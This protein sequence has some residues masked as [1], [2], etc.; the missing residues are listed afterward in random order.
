MESSSPE[1][2]LINDYKLALKF[3]VNK[4]FAKSFSI[5]EKLHDFC[6]KHFELGTLGEEYF[7][8][9]VTL[10]LTEVSLLVNP[11]DGNGYQ[12]SKV[13][14]KK[15][16]QKLEQGEFLDKLYGTYG[17]IPKIPLELLFQVFLVNYTCQNVVSTEH[18]A[19]ARQFKK[20]YSLLDFSTASG[21]KY[22]KRWVDMYVFNVLPD[23]DDFSTAF[24]VAEENPLINTDKARNKLEELQELKK[25][26]KKVRE[27]KAQEL[28]SKEARRLEEEKAKQR[29][30]KDE[31]D[32]KFKSLKQIRQER[33][34]DEEKRRVGANPAS[35][36]SQFTIEHLKS[37][38]E[39]L[40]RI[41][42]SAIQK[43]S[44]V[45]LAA[46]L[47]AFIGSRF[48][49]NRRINI[50]EKLQETLKMAFKVTYL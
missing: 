8:K 42:S 24:R 39:H 5:I 4:D 7:I 32:L 15:L 47:L 41:S 1:K 45:I 28:Q 30:S 43:N 3:F 34:Q 16:V 22:L 35:G 38:L 9:I 50:R 14:R 49:R 25:Q 2:V 27:K 21:D 19:L 26:E 40:L 33:E 31:S 46:L 12:M 23:A 6:Y 20:I 11:K 17:E 13:N 36:N 18:S 10:Y 29:K 48:L 37:R 44:P